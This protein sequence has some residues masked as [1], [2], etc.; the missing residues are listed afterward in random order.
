MLVGAG[1]DAAAGVEF[2][3]AL[4]TLP[5]GAGTAAALVDLIGKT[6]LATLAGVLAQARAVVANDSGAMHLAGAVG[7]PVVAIFGP[8]NER[9]T[10]P[11]T[12]ALHRA[13][14]ASGHP[15]RVVPGRVCSGSVRSD[16]CACA[17]SPRTTSPPSSHD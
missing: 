8:T 16:T 9:Q 2:T 5:G 11:L 1:G 14:A 7:A 12:A 13:A 6:D 15:F 4:S 3:A 17:V 10:A